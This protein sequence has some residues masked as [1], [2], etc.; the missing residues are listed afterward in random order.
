MPP[1]AGD[2]VIHP[3]PLGVESF[4]AS[5]PAGVASGDFFI[6]VIDIS[7]RVQPPVDVI[8]PGLRPASEAIYLLGREAVLGECLVVVPIGTVKTELEI[9]EA[10]LIFPGVT[11]AEGL[12]FGRGPKPGR[13]VDIDQI[14]W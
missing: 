14:S 5:V 11:S 13:G 7:L 2:R 9:F 12:Q 8:R 1:Q 6:L 3:H 10:E 4:R